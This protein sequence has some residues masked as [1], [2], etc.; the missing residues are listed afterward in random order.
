VPGGMEKISV[1]VE[2]PSLTFVSKVLCAGDKSC[3]N[4]LYHFPCQ[5][6]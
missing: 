3:S 2:F 1:V 5:D 6:R 4:Q